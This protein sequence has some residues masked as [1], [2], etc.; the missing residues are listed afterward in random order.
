MR[1]EITEGQTHSLVEYRESD[2][3]N[4]ST[5]K[6]VGTWKKLDRYHL[7]ARHVIMIYPFSSKISH[8][9]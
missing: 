2:I 8:E 6:D 4:I 7:K 1:Q 5:T 3:C 9:V